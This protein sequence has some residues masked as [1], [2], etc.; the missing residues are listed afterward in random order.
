MAGHISVGVRPPWARSLGVGMFCGLTRFLVWWARLY[1][2]RCKKTRHTIPSSPYHPS[3]V[4]G[5]WVCVVF[6]LHVCRCIH[7]H[8]PIYVFVYIHMFNASCLKAYRWR[9][10][11]VRAPPRRLR[12]GHPFEVLAP[13]RASRCSTRCASR[14]IGGARL[15]S[16]RRLGVCAGASV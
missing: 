11:V 5:V 6:A 3:C 1:H 2:Q 8:V 12:E 16:A 14:L 9:A 15:L 10:A 4:G 7:T 13:L